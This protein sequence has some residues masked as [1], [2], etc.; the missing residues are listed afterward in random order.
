MVFAGADRDDIAAL[1]FP[2]VEA[3]R[4][5]AG[6]AAEATPAPSLAMP[7]VRATFASCWQ[8]LAAASTGSLDPRRA[9]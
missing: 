9:R 8:E 7:R 1:V 4:K 3:C 6:L 5:L 2:D